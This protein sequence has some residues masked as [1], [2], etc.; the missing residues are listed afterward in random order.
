[1]REARAAT[2]I[3]SEHVV[4]LLEIEKLPSGTP[5]FVM[6]YLEGSDLRALLRERGALE[7]SLAVDYVLQAAQAVA[8]GHVKGVVHRDIKPSNLFLARRADGT[9]LIKVLD[10]GIAKTAES[11][12]AESSLTARTTC[13]SARPRT[14][15]P[16]SCKPA[17][18]RQAL[19]HL[20]RWA[21][22]LYELLC[23]ARRSSPSY[24]ELASHIL[25]QPPIPLSQRDVP[26]TL[27]DG[28]EAVLCKCLEKER[29]R[30]YANAGELAA[31]LA[32]FGSDD[33]RMSLSARQRHAGV[34]LVVPGAHERHPVD[35]HRLRATLDVAG[36]TAKTTDERRTSD[37]GAVASHAARGVQSKL[38]VVAIAPQPSSQSCFAEPR[39][40]LRSR[41]CSSAGSRR[42]RRRCRRDGSVTAPAQ[43]VA[44]VAAETASQPNDVAAPS[45]PSAPK[46]RSTLAAATPKTAASPPS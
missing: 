38:M 45:A 8:E 14:C 23:A 19:R 41:R 12:A 40:R 37:I 17:R 6:E 5:F 39:G 20:V 30:R 18:R 34:E 25:S 2:R 33:S 35:K 32:P 43:T 13:G 31:A 9:P 10:F 3:T 44:R 24:L 46:K 28:L 7:P 29:S 26:D 1:V 4:R 27:A 16:S 11:D 42:A 22:P 21:P 36:Q 15:R